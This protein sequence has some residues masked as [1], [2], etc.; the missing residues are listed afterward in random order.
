VRAG[1]LTLLVGGDDETL[2]R[3]R[4]ALEAY[5]DPILRVG[6]LGDG[7]RVKLINNALLGAHLGLAAEAERVA[8]RLGVE[9]GVA[10]AAIARCSGDSSALRLVV[11]MGSAEKLD[12]AAGRF[13]RKDAEMVVQVA[14]A[15]GVELGQ[16]DPAF[17]RDDLGGEGS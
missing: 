16:L 14:R 3:A 4:P 5:A 6:G 13:L 8:A 7:Q 2:A 10:L 15:A 12:A 11:T 1:T 17:W 9:P